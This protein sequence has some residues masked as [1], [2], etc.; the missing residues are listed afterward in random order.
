MDVIPSATAYGQSFLKKKYSGL[1]FFRIKSRRKDGQREREE[2]FSISCPFLLLC[3]S[4][5]WAEKVRGVAD[6]CFPLDPVQFLTAC[7]V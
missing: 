1:F 5:E 6:P 4:L 2:V 7:H 3:A